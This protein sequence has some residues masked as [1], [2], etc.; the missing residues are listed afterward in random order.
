MH[1]NC[2]CI[3]DCGCTV[4]CVCACMCVYVRAC[5]CVCVC[6]CVCVCGTV[7][8]TSNARLIR[9]HTRAHECNLMHC[10]PSCEIARGIRF[11]FDFCFCCV[12]GVLECW[13]ASTFECLCLRKN[14]STMSARRNSRVHHE[15]AEERWYIHYVSHGPEGSSTEPREVDFKTDADQSGLQLSL[16]RLRSVF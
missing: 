8:I 7:V 9:K 13:Y 1:R 3:V 12:S 16:R 2:L 15:E 4:V 6:V 10:F 11:V 5:A 14:Y